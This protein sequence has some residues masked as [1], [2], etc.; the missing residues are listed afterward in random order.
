V[1]KVDREVCSKSLYMAY[2]DDSVNYNATM[3]NAADQQQVTD[4]KT[5]EGHTERRN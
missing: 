3:P 1:L 2:I 5:V 4:T